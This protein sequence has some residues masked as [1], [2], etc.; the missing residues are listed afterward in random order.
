MQRVRPP[1]TSDGSLPETIGP[2]PSAHS[3]AV[4]LDVV[5]SPGV[6]RSDVDALLQGLAR[7]LAEGESPRSRADFLLSLI[8]SNEVG[9]RVGSENIPLRAVAIQALLDMGYPYALEIPPEALG[10]SR[11]TQNDALPQKLPI[12]GLIATLA[13]FL[14][15]S[16]TCLPSVLQLLGEQRQGWSTVF[17]LIGLGVLLGPAFSSVLGGL[18]RMRHLQRFGLITMTLTGS[19]WMLALALQFASTGQPFRHSFT[20]VAL[21]AGLGFLVGA[22]FTRTPEWLAEEPSPEDEEAP[23]S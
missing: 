15:Q 14:T 2:L 23:E 13:G 5:R 18:L 8:E 19:I 6:M 22:L 7:P 16:I 17:A 4:L 20:Y 9:D 1:R 10:R 21:V 11:R 3:L 12:P